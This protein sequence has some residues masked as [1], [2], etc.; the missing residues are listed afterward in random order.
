MDPSNE[1][2]IMTYML[3]TAETEDDYVIIA[4][5]QARQNWDPLF[6]HFDNLIDVQTLHYR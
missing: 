6:N 5:L 2:L 4:G 3:K 1:S